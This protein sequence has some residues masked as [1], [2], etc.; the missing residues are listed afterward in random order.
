M[1]RPAW[2]I[3]LCEA[4]GMLIYIPALKLTTVANVAII[5]ATV[6]L[7]AAGLAWTWIRERPPPCL[8]PISLVG[9]AGAMVM[10]WDSARMAGLVGDALALLM[11]IGMA[12]T[13]VALRKYPET[14]FLPVAILANLVGSVVV[15]P[16]AEVTSVSSSD[17]AYMA[18]FGVVQMGL[19]LLLFGIGSKLIPAG[20]TA[21]IGTLETPLAPLL[22]WIAVGETPSD[23]SL[24]GGLIVFGAVVAY[25]G[26]QARFERA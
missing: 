16:F 6:P 11:T 20:E 21:L 3:T 13:M 8:V 26:A 12:V 1:K 23:S 22:V 24:V 5:Y 14:P 17:M 2:L 25:L 7:F 9:V 10:V 19:G 18:V 4:A 15:A